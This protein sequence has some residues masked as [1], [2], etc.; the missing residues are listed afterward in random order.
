MLREE[1]IYK[2]QCIEQVN[3]YKNAL[4]LHFDYLAADNTSF[5]IF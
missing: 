2:Y 5:Y 4:A 1:F 3:K